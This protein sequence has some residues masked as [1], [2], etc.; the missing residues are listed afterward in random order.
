MPAETKVRSIVKM[1]T[2]SV[3]FCMASTGL[4]YSAFI[5]LQ[6]LSSS[7]YTAW[8]FGGILAILLYAVC[9][10]GYRKLPISSW[11]G[12]LKLGLAALGAGYCLAVCAAFLSSSISLWTDWAM[13]NTP[14]W[15]FAVLLSVAVGYGSYC[16]K[17]AVLRLSVLSLFVLLLIAV[18]DTLMLL[19]DIQLDRLRGFPNEMTASLLPASF[20]VAALL[21]LPLP[22]VFILLNDADFIRG[23][24]KSIGLGVAL[25]V[26]WLVIAA[27]RSVLLLGVLIQLDG[28]PMISSLMEADAGIGLVRLEYLGVLAMMNII[29]VGAMGILCAVKIC[30]NKICPSFING[31]KNIFLPAAVFLLMIFGKYVLA[32]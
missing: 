18:I 9:S 13:E 16:G 27:V 31:W 22:A 15:A 26:L 20:K 25:L 30:L 29:I 21:L 11:P 4:G 10:F 6:Q 7:Y 1:Q 8:I 17:K 32:L 23:N 19:P 3:S 24:H 12:W 2:V 5:G 28:Y 14:F